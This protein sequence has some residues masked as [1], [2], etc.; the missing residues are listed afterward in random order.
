MASTFAAL[1]PPL[2]R[3]LQERGFQ[4]PTG[5]QESAI[6]AILAGRDLLL[7]A[8]TGT[9]KT[10]AALLPALHRILVERPPPLFLL[11]I[12]PLRALNRDMEERV[13]WWASRLDVSV[14]VRHGDTPARERSK[15]AARPPHVLFTTPE[16]F[17]ILLN[18]RVLGKA[19]LKVRMVVVD[20]VH[21]MA[22]SKRGTQ[23]FLG[24]S[25][26]RR[27]GA[28]FQVVGLSATVGDPGR[29]AALLGEPGRPVEVVEAQVPKAMELELLFPEAGP[30]DAEAAGRIYA[31]P[32]VAARLRE[33]S[34]RI[35][36]KTALVFT[37][38]RP[39]AE[40][41]G[42][43]FRL[44][45][46][47]TPIMVHHGSLSYASR[48]A[49]ERKLKSG[50]LRAV[51]CTSSLEL[52]IDVG[53]VEQVIQYGSPRQA[54]RLVQRVGRSGHTAGGT[55]RGVV[56]AQN[57]EDG[58]E[59]LVIAR[60]ARREGPEPPEIPRSPSDV[61]M[62]S[63]AGMLVHRPRWRTEDAL[64]VARGAEPYRDLSREELLRVLRHMETLDLARVQSDGE[65]FSRHGRRE[66]LFSYFYENLS[67]IPETKQCLVVNQ[68]DGL[69]VG[70]LDEE[71]MTENGTP[72]TKFVMAGSCWRILAV[73]E[74][75]VEVVPDDDP[76]GAIPSW[77]GEE[78]PV[79][80]EVAQEVGA[81]RRRFSEGAGAEE[82]AREYP[83]GPDA[84]RK[85][86]AESR[87]HLEVAALPTDRALLL[88]R[89]Q[90]F[91]VLHSP[92]GTRVNRTLARFLAEELADRGSPA[93]ASEDAYR[94]VLKT[95]GGPETLLEV[96]RSSSRNRADVRRQL[97]ETVRTSI[98]KS[99]YFRRRFAQV[100]KRMG[101]V[102]PGAD[103]STAE[104][105]RLIPL[106]SDTPVFDEAF[107]E[108]VGRDLD[109]DRTVDVLTRLA[110]GD[111][112]LK[113][114]ES[115][116]P[117]PLA[118]IALESPKLEAV[119]RRKGFLITALRGRLLSEPRV[120][121]CPGCGHGEEG[122]LREKREFD[123][124]KCKGPL[125]PTAGGLEEALEA[126]RKKEREILE[127]ARLAEKHG[128]AG[129][130]VVA[131]RVD[132]ADRAAVLERGARSMDDLLEAILEAERKSLLRRFESR[133]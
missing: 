75:R 38:T 86:L 121:V 22:E 129:A 72:G 62:H 12:T 2:R 76:T 90:D 127:A 79:P 108:T 117:T 49:A 83:A 65:A 17:Q 32:E 51:I 95:P 113:T 21:E 55:P 7:I 107:R 112:G 33:V 100:A 101:A 106:L 128:L 96:L 34:K 97:E 37:N 116:E 119:G 63:L 18:A 16:T 105:E 130:M 44:L 54:T 123:C 104:I 26:L 66:R 70:I 132:R 82:F 10:E 131:S 88:E 43:R 50:E 80:Y 74:P 13:S 110:S 98:V 92:C 47:E 64:A 6:P 91:T 25:R 99:K 118:R 122:T 28:E 1:A 19:L 68:E 77:V 71:F 67:M 115:A 133:R 29:V 42:S 35:R 87:A 114:V 52:G 39:T 120:F 41:L 53:Q 46:P 58:L 56:I 73:T 5:P 15:Q 102:A 3:L 24:L 78:I 94:V 8:P 57:G 125:A 20:E 61:L 31:V 103:L 81:V 48:F 11:C 36:G 4:V 30:G 9:G 23:L 109:L 14:A 69:P 40:S 89:W 60:R 45:E 27:M 59:S 124:P 111:L 126:A 85:C 93:A 84:I